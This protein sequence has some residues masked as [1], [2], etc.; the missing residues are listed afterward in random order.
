MSRSSD[1]QRAREAAYRDREAAIEAAVHV[2]RDHPI[3]N[4]GG[5]PSTSPKINLGV[6]GRDIVGFQP[7]DDA[8]YVV[9]RDHVE[10]WPADD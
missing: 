6:F 4:D 2:D 3:Q 7:G 8:V 5:G 9:F 1:S 10:V